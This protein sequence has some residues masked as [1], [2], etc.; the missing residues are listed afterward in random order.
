MMSMSKLKT[1]LT[2]FV[3]LFS[4]SVVANDDLSGKSIVCGTTLEYLCNVFGNQ[5]ECPDSPSQEV[6]MA[7][8]FKN[9]HQASYYDYKGIF[10][11]MPEEN[12]EV[13]LFYKTDLQ[14]IMVYFDKLDKDAQYIYKID[15]KSLN[16]IFGENYYEGGSYELTIGDSCII[17][18]NYENIKKNI[19][20][21]KNKIIA[22]ITKENK[23]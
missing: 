20:K 5:G 4:S 17:Y 3:L 19:I 1:L 6:I 9:K 13:P 8:E 11:N 16:F 22:E 12:I 14:S 2:I 23:I 10:F 7:I 18:E 21:M 15:R